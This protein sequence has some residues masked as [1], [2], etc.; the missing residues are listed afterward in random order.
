MWDGYT[1]YWLGLLFCFFFLDRLGL[2]SE[3]MGVGCLLGMWRVGFHETACM[4]RIIAILTWIPILPR[5]C[6]LSWIATRGLLT[7]PGKGYLQSATSDSGGTSHRLQAARSEC[8]AAVQESLLWY[9]FLGDCLWFG[10]S[11]RSYRQRRT[12]AMQIY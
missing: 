3:W 4:M 8:N 7:K 11:C 10:N 5:C 6:V 9:F 1:G 2:R 12:K